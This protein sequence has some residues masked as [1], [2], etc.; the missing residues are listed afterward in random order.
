MVHSCNVIHRQILLNISMLLSPPHHVICGVLTQVCQCGVKSIRW[1]IKCVEGDFWRYMRSIVSIV[2]FT[3]SDARST[4]DLSYV[5]HLWSTTLHD[6][7]ETFV[8]T[9]D[10]SKAF[11]R[12]WHEA[13]L[14]KLPSFRIFASLCDLFSSILVERNISVVV[15]G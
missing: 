13:L 11:V 2:K 1:K 8:V 12:V 9:L 4:G 15:N 5:T 7:G 14:A 6:N 3:V 10:I